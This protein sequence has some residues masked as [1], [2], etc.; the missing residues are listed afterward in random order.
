LDEPFESLEALGHHGI[1]KRRAAADGG[2]ERQ[3]CD[4]GARLARERAVGGLS[5]GAEEFE[6]LVDRG[7]HVRRGGRLCARLTRGDCEQRDKGKCK[8]SSAMEG[9]I[10]SQ[11]LRFPWCDPA[12]PRRRRHRVAAI[13]P[14]VARDGKEQELVS[15]NT[16]LAVE[17]AAACEG[18]VKI[19]CA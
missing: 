10:H 13:V 14:R 6:G 12:T 19:K 4:A 11:L 3:G 15:V 17:S 9:T 1:V 16:A 8:R 2:G 5:L 7:L 18:G